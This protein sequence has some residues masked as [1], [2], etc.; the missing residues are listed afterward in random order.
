MDADGRTPEEQAQH[1]RDCPHCGMHALMLRVDRAIRASIAA[2][3]E[4]HTA[5]LLGEQ[6]VTTGFYA[7]GGSYAVATRSY[8]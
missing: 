6:A 3:G 4:I 8:N 1:E 2:P 7:L 5:T